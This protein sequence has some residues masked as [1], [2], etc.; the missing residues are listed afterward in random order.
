MLLSLSTIN[1]LCN[2]QFFHGSTF[3]HGGNKIDQNNV[4]SQRS[5]KAYSFIGVG[6][7]RVD[8]GSRRTSLPSSLWIR[9]TLP[10]TFV[11]LLSVSF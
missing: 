5:F 8:Q 6:L 3:E 1:V 11:R 2:I 4:Y 10:G 7:K 9:P